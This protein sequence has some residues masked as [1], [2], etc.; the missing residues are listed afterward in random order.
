LPVKYALIKKIRA[1]NPVSAGWSGGS[2]TGCAAPMEAGPFHLVADG[3]GVDAHGA[4][5][6]GGTEK[7][8][9]YIYNFSRLS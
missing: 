4:G 7:R 5:Q 6:A 8:C 3:I 2:R 1:G 9:A